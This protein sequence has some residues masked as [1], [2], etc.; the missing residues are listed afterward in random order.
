M[1]NG[2]DMTETSYIK[3]GTARLVVEMVKREW[4]QQWP[5]FL[6]EL[7][8]LAKTGKEYQIEVMCDT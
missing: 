1:G 3:D 7:T 2:Y 5:N 4:P 8:D 6:A